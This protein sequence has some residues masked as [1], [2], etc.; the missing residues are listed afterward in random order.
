MEPECLTLHEDEV[1]VGDLGVLPLSVV[2][3]VERLGSSDE[4][5][6]ICA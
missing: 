1:H 2:A 4:R 5:A 6:I 3:V